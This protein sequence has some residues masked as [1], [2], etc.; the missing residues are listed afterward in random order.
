M[1][2]TSQLPN[3]QSTL[4]ISPSPNDLYKL[5]S[6]PS[7]VVPYSLSLNSQSQPSMIPEPSHEV[8][9]EPEVLAN[10]TN[11]KGKDEVRSTKDKGGSKSEDARIYKCNKCSRS[12]LS[13]PALYTH[14][15][16]KHMY[17]GENASITNGRMRGRPRKLLVLL[18]KLL[19]C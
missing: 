6:I 10:K 2:S 12:Y 18:Y 19:D 11:A 7:A 1:D 15:K 13:Y 8:K 3:P 4:P 16:L 9:E 17:T 5:V 14:T